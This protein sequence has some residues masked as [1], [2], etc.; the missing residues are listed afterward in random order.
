[1][2]GR[3]SV[4]YPRGRRRAETTLCGRDTECA[5]TREAFEQHFWVQPGAAEALVLKAFSE[6]RRRIVAVAERSASVSNPRI[7]SM[8]STRAERIAM[9]S[10][11]L[12]RIF[13]CWLWFAYD[14]SPSAA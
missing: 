5:V 10:V 14:F 6:G 11:S 13:N 3:P 1:M 12:C 7:A 9:V 4:R 2:D 8:S